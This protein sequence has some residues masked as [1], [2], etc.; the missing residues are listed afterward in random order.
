MGGAPAPRAQAASRGT[1]RGVRGGGPEGAAAAWG[2][3]GAPTG[4]PWGPRG[5][6]FVLGGTSLVGKVLLQGANRVQVHGRAHWLAAVLAR[7]PGRGLMTV[8]NHLSTFDDPF[9]VSAMLPWAFFLT[10]PQHGLT[11]WAMCAEDVCFRNKFFNAWLLNGKVLPVVRGAGLKQPVLDKVSELLQRG[12]WVHVFPEGG[13]VRTGSLGPLKWGTAKALCG[14]A[15]NPPLVVPMYHR[16]NQ[17]IMPKGAVL[18]RTGRTTT[19]VVGEPVD[20][21]D[22]LLQCKRAHGP[23][24]KERAYV[25]IMDRIE[26]AMK[27]LEAPC[28]QRHA[29][30]TAGEAH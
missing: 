29:E 17:E 18:P 10:E 19:V 24:A 21:G 16:G 25:K 26:V 22:L 4:A 2:A 23:K 13:I 8:S 7:P 28:M 14:A 9:L 27:E 30:A 15:D 6:A 20:L 5:R 3:A 11:R 12:D 1:L